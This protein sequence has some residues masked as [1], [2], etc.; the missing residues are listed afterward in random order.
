MEP[1]LP[2][3]GAACYKGGVALRTPGDTVS[4]PVAIP[5][6]G[7]SRRPWRIHVV[8]FPEGRE[9]VDRRTYAVADASSRSGADRPGPAPLQEAAGAERDSEG[10]AEAQVLREA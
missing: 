5:P 1:A 7:D 2:P 6:G 3:Y 4:T 9:G 8:S 10:V